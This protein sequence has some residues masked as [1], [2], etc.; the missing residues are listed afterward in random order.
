MKKTKIACRALPVRFQYVRAVNVNNGRSVIVRLFADNARGY[1][2]IIIIGV[3][4]Y[5]HNIANAHYKLA[6]INI[7]TRLWISIVSFNNS[8]YLM[9]LCQNNEAESL[10]REAEK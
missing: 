3:R 8:I 6:D 9:I 4:I 10:D 2:I 5:V 1:T 7:I